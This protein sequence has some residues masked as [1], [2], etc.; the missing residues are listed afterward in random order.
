[1]LPHHR[2]ALG[3]RLG[4]IQMIEKRVEEYKKMLEKQEEQ[5]KEDIGKAK[6]NRKIDLFCFLSPA[7]FFSIYCAVLFYWIRVDGMEDKEQ[8]TVTASMDTKTKH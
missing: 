5:Y 3:K 2:N 1:M 4:E 6:R 7:L 8:K